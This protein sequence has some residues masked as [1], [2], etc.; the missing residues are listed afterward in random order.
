M[1]KELKTNENKLKC[2]DNILNK[3]WAQYRE[4][5]EP[6]SISSGIGKEKVYP[7]VDGEGR[8][9]LFRYD[10][11]VFALQ[12]SEMYDNSNALIGI[13]VKFDLSKV[14]DKE[15]SKYSPLA[16]NEMLMKYGSNKLMP[17]IARKGLTKYPGFQP[18]KET[19]ALLYLLPISEVKNTGEC[20]AIVTK[21]FIEGPGH[22]IGPIRNYVKEIKSHQY[23]LK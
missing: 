19:V 18:A 7:R 17:T 21:K 20:E 8:N 14:R 16:I 10:D 9:K 5:A 12:D 2:I 4:M 11:I 6:L 22:T 23:H 1:T 3:I 13:N 15:I